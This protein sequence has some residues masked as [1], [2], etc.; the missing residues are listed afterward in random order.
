MIKGLICLCLSILGI[1]AR[2][3]PPFNDLRPISQKIAIRISNIEKFIFFVIHF[4]VIRL[5]QILH[6]PRQ[7]NC[8]AMCKI[9]L[10]SVD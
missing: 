6:M 10:G 2:I 7:H 5:Q 3:F 4:L 8:R 9:L 1:F